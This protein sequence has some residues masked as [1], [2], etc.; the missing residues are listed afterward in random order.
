VKRPNRLL[1]RIARRDLAS[2]QA[3]APATD[4]GS[5]EVLAALERDELMLHFQP[6]VDLRSGECRR[7]E[8]LVRWLHPRVGSIGAR[9]IVELAEREG[10]LPALMRWAIARAERQRAARPHGRTS[11]ARWRRGVR[12]AIANGGDASR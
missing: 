12:S 4:I 6:I 10:V 3:R 7:A 2:G 8:A 1:G 9:W 11:R 5:P